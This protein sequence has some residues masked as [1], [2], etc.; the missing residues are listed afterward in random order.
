MDKSEF[1]ELKDLVLA[2]TQDVKVIKSELLGATPILLEASTQTD[3]Q[4]A[5]PMIIQENQEIGTQ[6]CTTNDP[7]P[8]K[9][10]TTKNYQNGVEKGRQKVPTFPKKRNPSSKK[11]IIKGIPKNISDDDIKKELLVRNFTLKTVNRLTSKS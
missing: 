3:S 2:L 1:Q 11:I 5:E 9:G 4:E 6:P 8:N 10:I 7:P